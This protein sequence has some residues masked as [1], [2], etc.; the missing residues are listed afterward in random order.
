MHTQADRSVTRGG[1]R[2]AKEVAK[3][4]LCERVRSDT[5]TH[6]TIQVTDVY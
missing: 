5:L 1:S 4:G 3:P 6:R 2:A